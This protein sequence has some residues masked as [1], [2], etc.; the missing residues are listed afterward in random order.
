MSFT[1]SLSP[2]G[3]VET[4]VQSSQSANLNIASSTR[5]RT[6]IVLGGAAS[7]E[8]VTSDAGV[9]PM[10]P[11][12]VS[13]C[14]PS[15]PGWPAKA[16]PQRTSHSLK[17]VSQPSPAESCRSTCFGCTTSRT[18]EAQPS[19]RS[20]PASSLPIDIPLVG[21]TVN[22]STPFSTSISSEPSCRPP[23]SVRLRMLQGRPPIPLC[24]SS[25]SHASVL[26][27]SVT[28]VMVLCRPSL[29]SHSDCFIF[30]ALIPASVPP[31]STRSRSADGIHAN[32]TVRFGSIC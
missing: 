22:R 28:L 24:R 3:S 31:T 4:S 8:T 18:G 20:L 15:V 5:P 14:A 29:G 10:R 12:R 11:C 16:T 32:I 25:V 7:T 19:G 6:R 17:P 21:R 13:R 27:L 1:R 23:C 30:H 26:V 2:P 9:L